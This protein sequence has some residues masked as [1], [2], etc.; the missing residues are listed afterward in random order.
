VF[1][2]ACGRPSGCDL[3]FSFSSLLL[4]TSVSVYYS[5][6][7]LCVVLCFFALCVMC[8]SD[9]LY[10]LWVIS[11]CSTA[12]VDCAVSLLSCF[13][14]PVVSVLLGVYSFVCVSI[15]LHLL[16]QIVLC[17]HY[18]SFLFCPLVCCVCVAF[19]AAENL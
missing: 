5:C 8:Y 10:C 14:T 19:S 4:L 3:F 6:V 18:V 17:L 11:V 9:V 16:S 7:G 12:A 13:N 2:F 15:L 1:V